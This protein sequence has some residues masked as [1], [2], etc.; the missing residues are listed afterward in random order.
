MASVELTMY[1]TAS[2]A[3]E[4][5]SK[6]S[7]VPFELRGA[8]QAMGPFDVEA[9]KAA[10]A[11]LEA[12]LG[13]YLNS[14]CNSLAQARFLVSSRTKAVKAQRTAL[15]KRLNELVN[16]YCADGFSVVD[17]SLYTFALDM[18]S[19]PVEFVVD[20]SGHP[21]GFEGAVPDGLP[22]VYDPSALAEFLSERGFKVDLL[23]PS[24]V[25]DASYPAQLL[26]REDREDGLTFILNPPSPLHRPL[27]SLLYAYLR[28]KT[29][30]NAFG[31]LWG[32]AAS[33]RLPQ[34]EQAPVWLALSFVAHLQSANY[35]PNLQTIEESEDESLTRMSGDSV[36]VP[37][38]SGRGPT[39]EVGTRA[40]YGY[41]RILKHVGAGRMV[42]GYLRMIEG[43]NARK[44]AISAKHGGTTSR[45]D[46]EKHP[47]VVRDPFLQH[48]NH[49]A[50]L[51]QEDY[52][53]FRRACA[54]ASSRL[55]VGESFSEIFGERL[56]P[57]HPRIGEPHPV[58]ATV[59][60]LFK[61]SPVPEG[62]PE[63]ERWRYFVRELK[64]SVG[65]HPH[66]PG[67]ITKTHKPTAYLKEA[68]WLHTSARQAYWTDELVPPV[69]AAMWSVDVP[70]PNADR[71]ENELWKY[72]E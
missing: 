52:T 65:K 38:G 5:K 12:K 55:T 62:V 30:A 35:R 66:P 33:L 34:V 50:S 40:A 4:A 44:E 54:K 49:A 69:K 9:A 37:D 31:S 36:W 56:L 61:D 43:L 22:F 72:Y 45:M 3:R 29:V 68:R 32:W 70:S 67:Y 57:G 10:I 8:K 7:H 48:W 6:N 19:G 15:L 20:D 25:P 46:S 14:D 21:R 71:V 23:P 16:D 17:G 13:R 47:F 64:V 51:T 28:E 26:C 18:V 58:M 59:A 60:H 42:Y 2:P 53:Y 63:A 41:H 39:T 11:P 24:V 27:R 1:Q